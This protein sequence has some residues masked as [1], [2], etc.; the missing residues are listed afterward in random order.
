MRVT[1]RYFAVLRERR[2]LGEEEVDLTDGSTAAEAWR[3]LSPFPGEVTFP[4][5]F[6]INQAIVA[7]ATV[8][9]AGDELAF[10]PPVGGG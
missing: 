7:G 5:A 8:L 3:R 2:G 4:V 6:A 10:L 9:R 1:V